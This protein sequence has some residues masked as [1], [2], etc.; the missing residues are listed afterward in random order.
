MSIFR[1]P[2]ELLFLVY[3]IQLFDYIAECISDFL[4]EHQIKHKKLPLGFTFSF[5]V[6]HEDLDKVRLFSGGNMQSDNTN[7]VLWHTFS[8]SYRCLMIS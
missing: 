7:T 8:N 4:D 6:R 1:K 5:P 2:S 3:S